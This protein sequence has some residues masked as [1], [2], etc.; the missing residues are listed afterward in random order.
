[1][2]KTIVIIAIAVAVIG[3]GIYYYVLMS[4]SNYNYNGASTSINSV[5][6][7]QPAVPE[8][9]N[10]TV[11]I[12]NFLFNPS[13]LTIK[14]GTKITWVNNDPVVHTITSDSGNLLNSPTLSLG[15]SFSFI[16]TDVGTISYHCNIHKT[17]KATITVEK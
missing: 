7:N 16:F 17:M 14:T 6:N 2:K 1:M 9:S 5:A 3:V 15:Q 13:T 10:I 8:T 11:D 4:G 12:K